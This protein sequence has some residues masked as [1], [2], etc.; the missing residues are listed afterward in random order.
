MRQ[1]AKTK[2]VMLENG[3]EDTR[4]NAGFIENIRGASSVN[5][6]YMITLIIMIQL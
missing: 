4:L 5:I 3:K 2:I 6:A 1:N